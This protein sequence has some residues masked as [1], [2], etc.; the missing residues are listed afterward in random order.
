MGRGRDDGG[1]SKP[2]SSHMAA[3]GVSHVGRALDERPKSGMS[4]SS[5]PG[6]IHVQQ[7]PQVFGKRGLIRV[8]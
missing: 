1:L 4:V 3:E 8:G 5:E 6:V 7:Q 2:C